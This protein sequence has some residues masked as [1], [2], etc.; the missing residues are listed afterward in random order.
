[1]KQTES[2][3][4]SLYS[5]QIEPAMIANTR[6][7]SLDTLKTICCIFVILEH[8]WFVCTWLNGWTSQIISMAVPLFF[9]TS[10]YFTYETP[11][12]N[13]L[14]RW[15]RIGKIL[16]C[17]I[18][19][20]IFL[21]FAVD[22]YWGLSLLKIPHTAD[23]IWKILLFNDLH[24]L[25]R[26]HLWYL[27]AY[28]YVI[29]FFALLK[30]T[31]CTKLISLLPTLLVPF[32]I[33]SLASK[34]FHYSNNFM[35]IGIPCFAIGILTKK[36]CSIISPVFR[37]LSGGIALFSIMLLIVGIA[38]PIVSVIFQWLFAISL[39]IFFTSIKQY[40]SN[41]FS[42]IGEHYTL[43]IYVFHMAVIDLFFN[44]E[45]AHRYFYHMSFVSPIIVFFLT[46]LLSVAYK[47]GYDKIESFLISKA[48]KTR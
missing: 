4:P 31:N 30:K 5:P 3:S 48:N 39:F 15:K 47:Y 43:Y 23:D 41:I 10:G 8:L 38:N 32:I 16:L 7:H 20:Y 21:Y 45:F 2:D 17:S 18:L 46:L 24:T 44:T 27:A 26:G 1:M 28:L 11:L 34:E 6:N 22:Y 13:F 42:K 36:Y 9:M 14:K 33:I 37:Y 12:S 25:G 40:R 29:A 35:F 19:F